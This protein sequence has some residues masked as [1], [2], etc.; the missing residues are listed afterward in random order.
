MKAKLIVAVAILSM[1]AS[2]AA[3]CWRANSS[4]E[5]VIKSI[6]SGDITITLSSATGELKNGANELMLSFTDAAGNPINVTA[7]STFTWPAM[8]AMAEMNDG[9]TL[10]TTEVPGKFRARVNIE[11]AGSWEAKVRFKGRTGR[12]ERTSA[13]R[14]K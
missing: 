7:R 4:N 2:F 9:A 14:A 13:V 5:K 12:V 10:T 1:A 8:G 11:M 3:A 6:K